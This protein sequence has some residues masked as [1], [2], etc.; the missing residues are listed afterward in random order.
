M[1]EG[2]MPDLLGKVIELI[3]SLVANEGLSLHEPERTPSAVYFV[4]EVG[5][6]IGVGNS[7]PSHAKSCV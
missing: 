6:H 7:R 3:K 5:L 2:N 4:G 1:L